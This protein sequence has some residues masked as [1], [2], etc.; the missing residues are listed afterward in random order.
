MTNLEQEQIRFKMQQEID[1][2][3]TT[4]CRKR[5]GQYSTP[6]MLAKDIV[7][8]SLPYLEGMQGIS[9]LEPAMGTGAL[10][11]AL[12]ETLPD[13]ISH[14]RG[15]ELDYDYFGVAQ[16]LW[17]G[18]GI[19]TIQGDFT[20]AFPDMK[21]DVVF[22]NPPYS[23]H[24]A[25]SPEEK[26]YLQQISKSDTA[27]S[28]SGLASM[29]C[30][31]LL[32]SL[33]WM[34]PGAVGIWLIPSEW[35]S[36][37]YGMA[38]RSFLIRNV[39]LL[40]IHTFDVYDL[41]FSDALVSSCVVWFKNEQSKGTEDVIFS[42]GEDLHKPNRIDKYA[43]SS[44][45]KCGKWPPSSKA[46]DVRWKIGDFFTIRRGIVT[47]DNDFFVLDE[48]KVKELD[49]PMLYLKPILPSPRHI[50]VDHI[51]A[52]PDGLPINAQKCFLLDCTGYAKEALPQNVQLY[53]ASREH[54]ALKKKLCANRNRWY[55]QEQR[56]PTSF[57][58]SYMGR[59]A[60]GHSPVRFI[61]NDTNAIVS[62]SFLML[63]PR[64]QLK[65]LL[66]RNSQWTYDVW[67]TLTT[68]PTNDIIEAGRSYGGGLRKIEPLELASVPCE[69]LYHW[70][71][72]QGIE[73]H[74]EDDDGQLLLFA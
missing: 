16:K 71:T 24:Q 40:R 66:S 39:T 6:Y 23:R 36:V 30:Y 13:R 43:F 53:L 50:K 10:V 51:E 12:L 26:H 5:M 11:S 32:L 1:A 19:E 67:K 56:V 2:S 38:I 3:K 37:N 29:Y 64:K 7:E 73:V 70:M 72:V 52:G 8:E 31:F 34:K 28:V 22:A 59:Y 74:H 21:F 48:Q 65:T 17:A 14:V 60:E 27:I 47:G 63:Y 41:R 44:L 55:D 9:V 45:A 49:I 33:K 58:C 35:M 61:L 54:L 57:L 18:I 46:N 68:I 20:K 69:A 42:F 4:E 15:Y 62:N 25:I